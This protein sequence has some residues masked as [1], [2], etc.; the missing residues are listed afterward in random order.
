M[1]K[2]LIII[3]FKIGCPLF[4]QFM[5]FTF[6]RIALKIYVLKNAAFFFK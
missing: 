4:N 1:I 2:R 6:V 3:L 5:G